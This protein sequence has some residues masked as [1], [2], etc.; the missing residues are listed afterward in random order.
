MSLLSLFSDIYTGKVLI[1]GPMRSDKWPT[2]RALHLRQFPTCAACG[3]IEKLE[4]HH[5]NP[6]HLEPDLEL[7][8]LNLIT[9]CESD[10]NGVNCHLFFGHLGCFLSYNIDVC[11]DVV[12]WE[13]KIL[14]RPKGE[15]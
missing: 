12:A 3:G 7:D 14:N 10:K 5:I 9:L 6:F 11:I 4:A 8:P 1:D 2:I 15:E 13:R